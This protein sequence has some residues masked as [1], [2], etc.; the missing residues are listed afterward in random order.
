MTQLERTM[1]R[2]GN[3]LSQLARPHG[4]DEALPDEVQATLMQLGLRC[5]ERTPRTELI[6]E[7]WTRK[8]LLNAAFQQDVKDRGWPPSA[9]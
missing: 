4:C 6:A 7:L 2:L 9:A 8:R 5:D 3:A 1:T